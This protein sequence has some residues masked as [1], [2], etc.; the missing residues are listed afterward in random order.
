MLRFDSVA[1]RRGSKL[2]FADASVQLHTGWR[3]GVTGRNG[4][5]K[6]S[7]FALVAG[8]LQPDAGD[9]TRPRDWVLAHVRQETPALATSALDYVLDGDREYREIERALTQAEADH[10]ALTQARLHERLQVIGGYAARARASAL[11]HGL[12]FKPG[13]EQR[14]VAEFSGGWRMRLNLARR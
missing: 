6:S 4:A 10:D 9:F 12:G 5:G 1:L 3:V 13:E 14:K 7:L 11:M 8:E 2:L